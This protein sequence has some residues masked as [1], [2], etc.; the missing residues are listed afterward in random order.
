MESSESALGEFF[1]ECDEILQRFSATLAKV[2]KDSTVD[3]EIIG[4]LY[5]DTHTLKGSA[6]LFG[7]RL[8]GQIAHAMETALDPIRRLKIQIPSTL[9][10]GLF[11]AI[12]LIERIVRDSAGKN[13]ESIEIFEPEATIVV[14]KLLEAV[15]GI[16]GGEF[17][18]SNEKHSPLAAKNLIIVE[19]QSKAERFESA[20]GPSSVQSS[21]PGANI[22]AMEK[23]I[24]QDVSASVQEITPLMP[25]S[26]KGKDVAEVGA[27][28]S[29]TVRINVSL[30]DKL[31][32]L[33]G[34]MVLVRNQMLQYG[35]KHDSLEFLNLSQRLDVVTSDLQGEVMKTRMQPIGTILTKFQRLV[36]DLGK[37]LDKQIE[38]TLVGTE[39]ELDKTLLEA[40]KD[41]LTHIIRNSCDHGLEST[42]ERVNAG[43][44]A[45]GHIR[46]RSFH[47]G[48]HVIIE[49]GD[50][51]RGLNVKRILE[52]AIEKRII[53]QEQVT[54]LS[55]AEIGALIFAPGFSTA[56]KVTSVSGRGVGMDVVKTNIEKIGGQVELLNTQ[57][58]GMAVRLQIPLTL[59]IV[60]A[61]IVRASGEQFAIPQVK[62][63]ELVRVEKDG[64]GPKIEILQGK[65]V[66]R[67]RGQLLSLIDLRELLAMGGGPTTVEDSDGVNIVVLSGDG[68]SFGLIVDEIRDTADIVVKPLP[69]FIKKLQIFS[70]ATI[71]GDGSVSLILDTMGL[72]LRGNLYLKSVRRDQFHDSA[73]TTKLQ[74]LTNESQDFLF[75][76]L[77]SSESYCLPL[78][79]VQRL[80]EFPLS[81][82]QYSGQQR[83]VKY[84]GSILPIISLNEFFGLGNENRTVDSFRGSRE[85]ISLIVVQRNSRL[86]GIQVNEVVDILN[87]SNSIEEI[88][89]ETKGILGSV[90]VDKNVATVIDVF[91]VVDAVA[92][93]PE[94]PISKVTK[95]R[96]AALKKRTRVLFAEDTVFFVKQ[97]RKLLERDGFE[98]VHAADGEQAWHIL[99]SSKPGEYGMVLSDIEMPK[100]T[101]FELAEKVR[102]DSRFSALPM[103]ALTTKFRE[104]DREKGRDVGFTKY[105]EKLRSDELLT[106]LH[107][108]LGE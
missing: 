96:D 26:E 69:N 67:L 72:A 1:S 66:F 56:E 75:F 36:R 65:P 101:G 21:Q 54:K 103:I 53:A 59:A 82:V 17:K 84:R 5:R 105:L 73:G 43:K 20:K 50:D 10:D 12:D 106:A 97:V 95:N 47:E 48:G 18:T 62:L 24:K 22:V 68:E 27:E 92:G 41:P 30:L 57:G 87:V 13:K 11:K 29:T 52:K 83:M 46:V 74:N 76:R 108:I 7:F 15:S 4:A 104:V 79:L 19:L 44:S 80:E 8:I 25:E 60:P 71:M 70:G 86:L 33:V 23:T 2:E 42:E 38:L 45:T 107:E 89:K 9:I 28:A 63:A 35:Q 91:A 99:A 78:C 85:A 49:V 64:T 77:H 81:E 14:P 16:F 58:K 61:L 6:Q 34:E 32:N 98:V 31:M 102:A 51:G 55:D 88:V 37:D 3:S 94:K 100:M 93:A 39:T 90:I 40:I